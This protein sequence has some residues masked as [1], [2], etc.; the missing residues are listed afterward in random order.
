MDD[1]TNYKLTE[2][3]LLWMEIESYLNPEYL[4]NQ[5]SA[6]E[7]DKV[8]LQKYSK[9]IYILNSAFKKI[10]LYELYF[11]E[12]YPVSEKIS[13]QSALEHHI[14]AYLSDLYRLRNAIKKFIEFIVKNSESENL[15][16]KD[17]EG[18]M[19]QIIDSKFKSAAEIRAAHVHA[20]INFKNN[21]NERSRLLISMKQILPLTKKIQKDGAMDYLKN[22]SNKAFDEAKKENIK[23]AK[24]NTNALFDLI[25]IVF[26]TFEN[27]LYSRLKIKPIFRNQ[28]TGLSSTSDE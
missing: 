8:I 10:Q 21:L 11:S 3:D 9:Q 1:V 27:Y 6:G 23:M 5:I 28:I 7:S 4:K 17:L 15:N 13:N 18:K 24:D 2:F 25:N 14:H 26:T 16:M 19:R 12:F 22:E 20:N